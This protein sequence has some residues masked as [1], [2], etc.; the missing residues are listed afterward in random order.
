MLQSTDCQQDLIHRSK[1]DRYSITSSASE[2]RHDEPKYIGRH[3]VDDQLN[4]L[5]GAAEQGER[6]GDAERLGGLE[7]DDELDLG[8][9][10][11]SQ[12]VAPLCVSVTGTD[13]ASRALPPV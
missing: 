8:G 13:W 1:M 7:V 5:V 3:V 4:H 9:N 10:D 12:T 2:S 11:A 6:H